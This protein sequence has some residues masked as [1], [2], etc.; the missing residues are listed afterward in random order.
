MDSAAPDATPSCP[1]KTF[2]IYNIQEVL[3]SFPAHP[4]GKHLNFA[5]SRKSTDCSCILDHMVSL[6]TCFQVVMIIMGLGPKKKAELDHN[7]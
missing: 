7:I 2:R 5:K 4:V 3:A 6:S 1:G